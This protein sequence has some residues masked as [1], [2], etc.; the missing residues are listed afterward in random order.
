M[1]PEEEQLDKYWREYVTWEE[2]FVAYHNRKP[3][4]EE[5]WQ[6][7]PSKYRK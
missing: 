1:S 6:D 5:G 3:T 4:K 7:A 2:S